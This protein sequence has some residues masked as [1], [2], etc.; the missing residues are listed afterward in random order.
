MRKK[1]PAK[2]AANSNLVECVNRAAG[3]NLVADGLANMQKGMHEGTEALEYLKKIEGAQKVD[4]YDSQ[5]TPIKQE[6]WKS[7]II[8]P[9]G[10]REKNH[11]ETNIICDF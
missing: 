10:I 5:R 7:K 2:R 3:Y 11:N 8:P 1:E 6:V 9:P 4:A